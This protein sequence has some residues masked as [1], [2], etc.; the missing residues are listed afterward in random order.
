MSQCY[1]FS[2]FAS[3][4]HGIME[5]HGITL[6]SREQTSF[7]HAFR[8]LQISRGCSFPALDLVEKIFED[9]S[10]LKIH[11]N[12]LQACGHTSKKILQFRAWGILTL[13]CL[14]P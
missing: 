12:H 13:E 8:D 4:L 9:V 6:D 10:E 11:I 14:V 2:Q 3:H 5:S 1:Q 7:F